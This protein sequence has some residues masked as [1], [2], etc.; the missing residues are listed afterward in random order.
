MRLTDTLVDLV[1]ERATVVGQRGRRGPRTANQRG[2]GGGGADCRGQ[3]GVRCVVVARRG[4]QRCRG[5][6][7][8]SHPGGGPARAVRR[9]LGARARCAHA[10]VPSAAT[11]AGRASS[12]TRPAPGGRWPMLAIGVD[13]GGTSVRAGVVDDGGVA[14][15]AT[16]GAETLETPSPP[17]ST[18][19]GPDTR[20][21]SV[22]RAG[23]SGLPAV[24]ALRP[25]LRGGRA[26]GRPNVRTVPVTL[27]TTP[28]PWVNTAG[29]PRTD[30]ACSRAQHGI[31]GS[32]ARR[33]EGAPTGGGVGHLRSFPTVGRVQSG[34]VLGEVCSGTALAATAVE[35]ARHRLAP[36]CWLASRSTRRR[37]RRV[38]RRSRG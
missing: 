28:P 17:W 3:I 21:R 33:E 10:G 8:A 22:W 7:W 23:L 35:P 9:P 36:P 34:T 4:T 38:A 5:A 19:C 37:R 27:S 25:H 14:P 29:G 20:R 6:S 15:V 18:S 26:G 13:V 2:D 12:A 31:G 16:P 1:L 11:G 32:A 24:G 30:V